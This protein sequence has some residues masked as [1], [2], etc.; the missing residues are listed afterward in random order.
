MGVLDGGVAAVFGAAFGSFYLPATL[1]RDGSDP[2]YDNEGNIIGYGGGVD[3]PCRAQV[4]AASWAMR[5]SEGYVDG[6]VRIIVLTAGLGISITADHQITV[7]GKRWMIA[8]PELDA[9]GSHWVLRGR[10]AI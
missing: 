2:I 6:D 7:Q 5:Q 1:H 4:D 8:Q 9:A 10:A 3:I